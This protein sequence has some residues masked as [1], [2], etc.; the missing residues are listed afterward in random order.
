[1]FSR[2]PWRRRSGPEDAGWGP[3]AASLDLSR[4]DRAQVAGLVGLDELTLL[5]P[6][7]AYDGVAGVTCYLFAHRERLDARS[8]KQLLATSCLLVSKDCISAASWRAFPKV[9]E[10]M[11]SLAA[12]R[13]GAQLLDF[14]DDPLFAERVTVVAREAVAVRAALTAPVRRL[15]SRAV[16]GSQERSLTVGEGSILLGIVSDQVELAEAQGLL[17]ST[18][19]L[20][21]VLQ[22]Q[23]G[24]HSR[25]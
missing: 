10:V 23:A 13:T 8:G 3:L 22:A 5:E 14:P 25:W 18:L 6:A 9:H 20:H 7:F 2:L 17:S 24:F 12:S 19:S 1:M 15:V 16:A 4:I 11:S 21:T